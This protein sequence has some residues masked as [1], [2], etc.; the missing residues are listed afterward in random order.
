[1]LPPGGDGVLWTMMNLAANT[2]NFSLFPV[3]WEHLLK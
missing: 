2:T 3:S 1:M